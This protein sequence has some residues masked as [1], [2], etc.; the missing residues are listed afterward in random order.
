MKSKLITWIRD[1]NGDKHQVVSKRLR[2][3]TDAFFRKRHNL[4]VQSKIYWLKEL[5]K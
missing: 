1:S 3:E 2:F 5:V 4:K